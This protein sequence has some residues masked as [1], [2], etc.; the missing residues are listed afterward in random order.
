MLTRRNTFVKRR[1]QI[2]YLPLL[3]LLMLQL[4]VVFSSRGE[5]VPMKV[6]DQEQYSSYMSMSSDQLLRR[7]ERFLLDKQEID[8]ALMCFT[9]VAERFRSDMDKSEMKVCLEGYYGRW[10]TFFFGYGNA[11]LAMDDLRTASEIASMIGEPAP[12]LDYYY[13][14]CYM[15]IGINVGVDSMLGKALSYFRRSFQEACR[16]RDYRTLHR[17]F[18]NMCT[19]AYICDS[20]DV[21][22]PQVEL[23][24]KIKEPEM[25]RV[26]QSLEIYNGFTKQHKGDMRGA[27]ECFQRLIDNLPRTTENMRY[28]AS[29]Y[30]KRSRVELDLERYDKAKATLDSMLNLTYRYNF[31]DIRQSVY[32]MYLLY[33]EAIG[34]QAGMHEAN[35]HYLALK[36]S[37]M[38]ERFMNTFLEVSFS[39]ERKQMQ[40]DMDAMYYRS[41][42]K[43]WILALA[44]I[45][46]GVTV[47]FVIVLQRSNRKLRER[48][49]LLYRNMQ[50]SLNE[51][52][53]WLGCPVAMLDQ[54]G[55][56][57]DVES[58]K[59]D[60]DTTLPVNDE[61]SGEVDAEEK[62]AGSGLSEQMM[63]DLAAHIRKVI[64]HSP[65]IYDPEFSLGILAEEIGSNRKYVSQTIN[66]RFNT[67]FRT[68]VNQARIREAM[69]RLDDK[70]QYGD[71][72]IEGIAESVGFRSR[73]S[74]S[75]W[76]KRFTG[77]GAAEYRQIGG[78]SQR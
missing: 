22:A 49:E 6:W 37:L 2:R 45:M 63:D 36:D 39:T 46:L 31:P 28:L 10:Q 54:D 64:M 26:R 34:D 20:V 41:R 59:D 32:S 27:L 74:F 75:T 19:A 66:A 40:Q 70:R 25:W 4:S 50:Q 57:P 35:N 78:N 14:V 17:A 67:N 61:A 68:L 73:S 29:F 48:S 13:G 42:L 60:S 72:S 38:I 69:R 23:L 65:A 76:F 9:V 24:H 77:L 7:G 33:Y 51:Q 8:S 11:P 12:K 18:D 58:E 53:D 55:N 3:C 30:V 47:V 15:N 71:Y 16:Q 5:A 1:M 62:Y 44:G 21:L 43:G 52:E 56:D